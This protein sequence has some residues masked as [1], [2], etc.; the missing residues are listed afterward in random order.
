MLQ[1]RLAENMVRGLL[2]RRLAERTA[3]NDCS[4]GLL[5]KTVDM[6]RGG[7]LATSQ[8]GLAESLEDSQRRSHAGRLLQRCTREDSFRGAR[9]GDFTEEA[10]S[11]ESSFRGARARGGARAGYFTGTYFTEEAHA[12]NLGEDS[13]LEKTPS[14]ER[15]SGTILHAEMTSSEES[16]SGTPSLGESS[17]RGLHTG[18]SSEERASAARP[19]FGRR[20]L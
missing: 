1:G 14:D 19:R 13:F 5:Q 4:K 3:S 9:A 7:L 10:P 20:W 15:S 8:M 12:E 2:Q 17:L 6:V 18:I 11:D 16:S